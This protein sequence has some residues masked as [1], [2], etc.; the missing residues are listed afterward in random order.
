MRLIDGAMSVCSPCLR[1]WARTRNQHWRL[2]TGG[3][4]MGVITASV[5]ESGSW[6]HALHH[7]HRDDVTTAALGAAT[8]FVPSRNWNLSVYCGFWVCWPAL[9]CVPE[10]GY[11]GVATPSHALE[12]RKRTIPQAVL[13]L[14]FPD[15][16]G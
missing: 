11:G 13:A 2:A 6:T 1:P 10:P 5:A 12:R 16:S 14:Q 4:V 3:V 8:V 7:S 9:C 15:R